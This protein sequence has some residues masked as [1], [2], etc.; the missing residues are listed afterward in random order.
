MPS[1]GDRNLLWRLPRNLKRTL[2]PGEKRLSIILFFLIVVNSF[3]ELLGL[4]T[5][6]PVIGA[7]LDPTGAENELI[8]E[9]RVWF[10]AGLGE[11]SD[12]VFIKMLV[13]LMVSAFAFKALYGMALIFFQTRFSFA[14]AYRIQGVLWTWHF[15]RSLERM[16]SKDSGVLMSEITFW[17]VQYVRGTLLS[18]IGLLNDVLVLILIVVGL[19]AYDFV[20]FSSVLMLSMV[21]S[22]LVRW[23][24]KERMERYS[25]V[26]KVVDPRM[27]TTLNNA[28]RGILELLA[29]NA[30]GRVRAKFL[31][32][33]KL[34]FRVMSNSSI[35][36]SLPTKLYELLAVSSVALAI[37][38]FLNQ[39]EGQ[40]VFQSL[41]LLALASYRVMPALSQINQK[42]MG[43]RGSAY[44]LNW[45]EETQEAMSEEEWGDGVA[46]AFDPIPPLDQLEVDDLTLGYESLSEPVLQGLSFVFE[47]GKISS[48]VGPSGCGKS[49]L[50]NALLGLHQPESGGAYGETSEGRLSCYD[51]NLSAWLSHMAYLPQ[52]PYLFSG[53]VRENLDL[54]EV[55][56]SDDGV[57]LE[58]IERLGLSEALQG[59]GLDFQLNEG[60]SNL[61][62]GQQQRLA[63][64]RAFSMRKPVLILD[65]ATSALDVQSRDNVMG[66]LRE[67]AQEGRIVILVTH[68]REVAAQCDE[69]LD[70]EKHQMK[71]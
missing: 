62:G 26:R 50:L 34:G 41:T 64:V 48:V 8:A 20:V 30:V 56:L 52:S 59:E 35:L 68:D 37:L 27:N 65:E 28:I 24:T 44:L 61:S 66:M 54:S 51:Q 17:P 71:S 47:A 13:G 23:L 25:D 18:V 21:G 29:F 1:L 15:S 67:F 45:M 57:I 39:G 2:V 36:S 43:I 22:V 14:V 31:R 7:V 16:R 10:E 4:A 19:L 11:M 33:A 12:V 9:T 69:V 70:L 38:I 63:L 46:V 53:T 55:G 40:G 5:V 32:D 3:V 58:M 60:G 49:T 6:V 42:I